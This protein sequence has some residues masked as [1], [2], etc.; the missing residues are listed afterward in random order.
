MSMSSLKLKHIKMENYH[1]V[2]EPLIIPLI[3][4]GNQ[5]SGFIDI[6]MN[7]LWCAG[8]LFSVEIASMIGPEKAL[9]YSNGKLTTLLFTSDIPQT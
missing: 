4:T 6:P 3:S 5:F 1:C 2:E 7:H 9:T 8:T